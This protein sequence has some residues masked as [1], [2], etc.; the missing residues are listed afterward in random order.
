[1]I[2]NHQGKLL[3]RDAVLKEVWGASAARSSKSLDTYLVR[4]RKLFLRNGVDLASI[5]S[6]RPGIGWLVDSRVRPKP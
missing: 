3:R 5:L 6:S 4:L 2:A 1:M